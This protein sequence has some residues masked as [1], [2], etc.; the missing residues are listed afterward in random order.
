ML[1]LAANGFTVSREDLRKAPATPEHIDQMDKTLEGG[2][3]M[4]R[5]NRLSEPGASSAAGGVDF[6]MSMLT[7]YK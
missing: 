6:A 5:I 4:L 3:Y 2:A 1:G 7:K